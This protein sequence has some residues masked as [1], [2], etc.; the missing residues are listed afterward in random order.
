MCAACAFMANNGAQSSATA[1]CITS[2]VAAASQKASRGLQ[3]NQSY[4][5]TTG[6]ELISA[7]RDI[8]GE[9]Y[10]NKWI[11]GWHLP[12]GVPRVELWLLLPTMYNT[13][14]VAAGKP[15]TA[16]WL[17]AA[18]VNAAVLGYVS[19]KLYRNAV[20]QHDKYKQLR[21]AEKRL[22]RLATQV[23]GCV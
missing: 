4:S 3:R 17:V 15:A 16:S 9:F 11:C 13:M 14:S 12:C 21:R 1:V 19:Y 18:G 20:V 22:W 10:Y 8:C 2:L 5:P 7:L 23:C 6:T